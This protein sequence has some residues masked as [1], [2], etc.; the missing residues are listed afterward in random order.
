M[1]YLLLVSKMCVH[2][3]NT[4]TKRLAFEMFDIIAVIVAN[5]K[6]SLSANFFMAYLFMAVFL[7]AF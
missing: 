5:I 3:L 1:Q 6:F 4:T 7:F 2:L